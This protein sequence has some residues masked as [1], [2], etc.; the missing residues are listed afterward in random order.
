MDNYE[1]SPIHLETD[2]MAK[3]RLSF[4]TC[5]LA[6]G[7]VL[8][9]V[10]MCLWAPA[11]AETNGRDLHGDALPEGAIAR[12]GSLRLRAMCDSIRFSADGKTLVGMDGGSLIRIWD[13]AKGNLL[14][15]RRLPGRPE[16]SRW[17]GLRTARLPDGKTLLIGDGRSLEMWDIALEKPLDI[18][19]PKNRKQRLE[20]FAISDDRR[21]LL[22]A[23][24]AVERVRQNNGKGNF[25][26]EQKQNLVVWDTSTGKSHVLAND[27]S[28]VIGLAISPDGKRLAS[29]SYGKGTRVWETATRKMLW[30]EPKFNAEKVAFTP[31]GQRL[32]GA[33]GGSQNKW[34]IWETA[35]GRPSKKDHPP[36][37]GYAW[38]FAVSPDGE[39][40][41]IPT[42]TDYVLWD[43]K[44]GKVRQRWPGANQAGKGVFAPDGRSVVTYDTILRRWDVAT[45]KPLYADMSAAGHI[46]PVGQIFFTPDGQ[47][48]VSVGDDATIRIWDTATSKLLHSISLEG[49]NPTA[50]TLSQG[51]AFLLGVDERLIVHRWSM[52]D[53]RRGKGFELGQAKKVNLEFLDNALRALHI[54]VMPDGNK[55]AVLAWPRFPENRT[56]YSFSFWDLKTERH[57]RWGGDPGRG[58]YGAAATLSPDG[59]MAAGSGT[60]WDTMTGER[61]VLQGPEAVQ[62]EPLFSPDGRL[63]ATGG[64]VWETATGRPLLDLPAAAKGTIFMARA[65][66][67]FSPDGRRFVFTDADDIVVWDLPSRK[68]ILKRKAAQHQDRYGRWASA[69]FLF[70][71]DRRTIA[72]GHTDG[73]I[74]LWAVL[75]VEKIAGRLPEA[76]AIRLWNDLADSDP[77]KGYSA[78]WRFSQY[79]Q[80]AVPLLDKHFPP[81]ALPAKGEME[82]L[83]RKLDGK[84]FKERTTAMRR[85]RQLGHAAEPALRQALKDHPTLEGKKRIDALLSALAPSAWPQADELRAV[86]AVAVLEGC[87]SPASR[88]LLEQWSKRTPQTRLA[89]EAARALARVKR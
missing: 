29:S 27:E 79:S 46:A 25:T 85:L 58:F 80:E 69:G 7:C 8:A 16:R 37:V 40:L 68:V 28:Q 23:E 36:T 48:L 44:A 62:R 72:T 64:R 31:D 13:A 84:E 55:L 21:L 35:T 61:R 81:I 41:L 1:N 57:E 49:V 76:E 88:R 53:G 83:I 5:S 2:M 12:F 30:Q 51:G 89:L 18:A 56:K 42:T 71:P 11:R 66:A 86:R 6:G 70:S 32:I 3:P 59:R 50:W 74:L 47:R 26:Y 17:S 78:V 43:L 4:R 52:A 77:G 14:T 39:L 34:H 60:L 54:R 75:P 19:L 82:G 38:T 73:T 45:G 20:R 63:L 67:A 87:N 15:H 24:I 22:F 33:P 65:R 9:G 10:L